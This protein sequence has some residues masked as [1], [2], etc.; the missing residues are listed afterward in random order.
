MNH[1]SNRLIHAALWLHKWVPERGISG[2]MWRQIIPSACR[3][4]FTDAVAEYH[5]MHD[6]PDERIMKTGDQVI[7]GPTGDIRTLA[8]Y[9]PRSGEA[10]F[11]GWPEAVAKGSDCS[12][13]KIAT[14]KESKQ[15][16]ESLVGH[17]GI[18]ARDL[19]MKTNA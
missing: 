6:Q 14:V 3:D 5:R 9:D 11:I 12:I 4:N 17:R 2:W 19:L 15:I 16:I 10:S 13:T 7:H 8:Y 1:A 18:R